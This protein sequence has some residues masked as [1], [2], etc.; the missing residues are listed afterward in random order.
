MAPPSVGGTSTAR[1]LLCSFLAGMITYLI[2][3]FGTGPSSLDLAPMERETVLVPRHKAALPQGTA[4]ASETTMPVDEGVTSA[5]SEEAPKSTESPPVAQNTASRQTAVLRPPLEL[6]P[7]YPTASPAISAAG[8]KKPGACFG[9]QCYAYYN[10]TIERTIDEVVSEPICVP[11]PFYLG[12]LTDKSA[13][14]ATE[15]P[16]KHGEFREIRCVYAKEPNT[17]PELPVVRPKLPAD[18]PRKAES[19]EQI[20]AEK[21]QVF[22]NFTSRAFKTWYDWPATC[23]AGKAIEGQQDPIAHAFHDRSQGNNYRMRN[24][25]IKPS[26]GLAGWKPHIEDFDGSDDVQTITHDASGFRHAKGYIMGVESLKEKPTCYYDTPLLLMPLVVRSNNPGHVFHR[27]AAMFD[28]AKRAFPSPEEHQ[29][30]TTVYAMME[31]V[32]TGIP[33]DHHDLSDFAKTAYT[34]FLGMVSPYH[35]AVY[36]AHFGMTQEIQRKLFGDAIK[37]DPRL[38]EPICF[39]EMVVYFTVTTVEAHSPN[40]GR[41]VIPMYYARSQRLMFEFLDRMRLCAGVG[42]RRTAPNRTNPVVLFTSRSGLRRW[43]LN[44]YHIGAVAQRV[45]QAEGTLVVHEMKDDTLLELIR[46]YNNVDVI[47]GP[48]GAGLFFGILMPPRSVVLE[49]THSEK[50]CAAHMGIDQ[51]PNFMCDYGGNFH[52][53]GVHHAVATMN[54]V[55][56]SRWLT[57]TDLGIDTVTMLLDKAL[58]LVK[59]PPGRDCNFHGDQVEKLQQS[60]LD[61]AKGDALR[62][63]AK[64]IGGPPHSFIR[65]AMKINS[66]VVTA[67]GLRSLRAGMANGGGKRVLLIHVC[68]R[69]SAPTLSDLTFISRYVNRHAM[70]FAFYSPV[71]PKRRPSSCPLPPKPLVAGETAAPLPLDPFSRQILEVNECQHLNR[72]DG[73]AGLSSLQTTHASAAKMEVQR[74]CGRFDAILVTS[75]VPTKLL[76]IL[77]DFHLTGDGHLIVAEDEEFPFSKGFGL[78]EKPVLS[79]EHRERPEIKGEEAPAEAAQNRDAADGD[80]QAQPQATAKVELPPAANEPAGPPL[81]P[82][83][84]VKQLRES[85]RQRQAQL[86]G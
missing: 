64:T 22:K 25:C 59:R 13:S 11:N 58:C 76:Q 24:I 38:F 21:L 27:M 60:F 55:T 73:T 43:V 31:G 61:D 66:S 32:N 19:V 53:A 42:P 20:H 10:E 56:Y 2:I 51:S 68:P 54:A 57:D 86:R 9:T 30:L 47:V 6:L 16:L 78:Q 40:Q 84:R 45:H 26:G 67:K 29:K 37:N 46:L 1:L 77:K 17:P 39:R 63:V 35:F 65:W 72:D 3:P 50:R 7:G 44:P 34:Q 33:N 74:M 82:K 83:E 18:L 75:A 36:G 41:E 23:T 15:A 49:I 70:L 5:P 52:T 81:S 8:C 69:E 79:V 14:G 80:T 85:L 28:I 71:D 4:T 12:R 62:L 48:Y